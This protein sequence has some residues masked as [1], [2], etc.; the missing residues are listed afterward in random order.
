MTAYSS[1]MMAAHRCDGCSGSDRL[2][3]EV[4]PFCEACGYLRELHV[5]ASEC[6]DETEARERWGQ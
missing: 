1:E 3:D 6:P 4:E 2:A 5:R